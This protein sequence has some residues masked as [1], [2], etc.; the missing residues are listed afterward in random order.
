[1]PSYSVTALRLPVSRIGDTYFCGGAQSGSLAI[2]RNS[3]TLQE[4]KRLGELLIDVGVR[5]LTRE[6]PGEYGF[7]DFV[8]LSVRSLL[9]R[10]FRFSFRQVSFYNHS[11]FSMVMR[12]EYRYMIAAY[13]EAPRFT[14][15]VSV[16]G[17]EG[18][19]G[20]GDDPLAAY[21][22]AEA[23]MVAHI[24]SLRG[25]DEWRTAVQESRD[26]PLK[27]ELVTPESVDEIVL[28]FPY[29]ASVYRE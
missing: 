1:M 25:E 14:W 21:L 20:F 8:E 10:F 18:I 17:H 26:S 11:G 27:L 15:R 2:L 28:C 29:Y 19:V 24:T 22:Q 3:V 4:S 13:K 9:E 16:E 23:K 6:P 5:G 12:A 7:V